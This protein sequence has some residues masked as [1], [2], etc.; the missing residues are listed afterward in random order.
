MQYFVR[1]VKGLPVAME[2]CNDDGE[3]IRVLFGEKLSIGRTV[4]IG[5]APHEHRVEVAL[6]YFKAKYRRSFDDLPQRV[7]RDI[8]TAKLAGATN[9]YIARAYNLLPKTVKQVLRG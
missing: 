9:G 8:K 1:V 6:E 3:L 4:F 2:R 7:K 5:N